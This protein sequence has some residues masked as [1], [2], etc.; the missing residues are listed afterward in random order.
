MTQINGITQIQKCLDYW[1]KVETFS[2]SESCSAPYH[3][4]NFLHYFFTCFYILL[5]VRYR[6]KYSLWI[7]F[8]AYSPNAATNRPQGDTAA[9][10]LHIV[11]V[12]TELSWSPTILILQIFYNSILNKI[13]LQQLENWNTINFL[14]NWQ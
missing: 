10:L 14:K 2:S 8:S 13:I 5:T 12:S 3:Q 11:P 4:I 6:T 1:R 9:P 7:V